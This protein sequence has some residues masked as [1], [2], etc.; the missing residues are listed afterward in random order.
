MKIQTLAVIFIIIV[1]PMSLV[2]TSYMRTEIKTIKLDTSYDS[3]L[4]NSTYDAIK[5]FQ[6]NTVNNTESDITESRISDIQASVNTFYNSLLTNFGYSGYN[7]DVMSEYVPAI[8]Y[9]MYD[10]YYIY[11]PY[12]NILTDV[13]YETRTDGDGISEPTYEN[14]D[15]IYGL[16]PYVYYSCR[17]ERKNGDDFVITYSLD[18]YI[19]VQGIVDGK[20]VN[21]SGYLIDGIEI[22]TSYQQLIN[23]DEEEKNGLRVKYDEVEIAVECGLEAFVGNEKYQYVKLNGT[24][25]YYDQDKDEIFYI[26]NGKKHTQVNSSSSE[27]DSYINIINN[28]N[29][30][31]RYYIEAFEFTAWVYNVLDGLTTESAQFDEG[32]EHYNIF[33]SSTGKNIQDSDS[34][35]NR[36]R[37][38]VIRNSIETNLQTAISNYAP[39]YTMPKISETD[40]D[41]LINNVCLITF[42]Q[43]MSIGGKVYNGYA[44]VKNTLNKEVVATD[45]IYI[46][47]EGKYLR[48]TSNSLNNVSADLSEAVLNLDFERHVLTN[49]DNSYIYYY[50][51]SLDKDIIYYGDYTSIVSQTDVN[52][53][54]EDIYKYMRSCRND[55]LKTLYYTALGRERY[56]AYKVNNNDILY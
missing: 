12:K 31:K 42:M 48:S 6:L 45:S 43:G 27:F 33:S 21:K 46:I 13:T 20:Y 24:K 34:N 3:K 44:V 15:L 11:S 32:T 14:D 19:T 10:G 51:K 23:M 26:L 56:G 18:N 4:L 40:W 1:L 55:K 53:E 50:P 37:L 2:L 17:Y 47:S 25:Y 35:F 29:S 54:Y 8:V 28:N 7:S 30:A 52:T 38:A 36:H 9:T 39:G 49:E 22:N 41:M 16:K 5:A